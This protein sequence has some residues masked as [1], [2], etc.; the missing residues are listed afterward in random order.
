MNKEG[1]AVFQPSISILTTA[2]LA[3]CAWIA[4]E[5]HNFNVVTNERLAAIESDIE[6]IHVT[7]KWI[8][9]RVGD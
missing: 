9:E 4:I 3:V 8:M 2:I 5:L 6:N 7:Q 1:K